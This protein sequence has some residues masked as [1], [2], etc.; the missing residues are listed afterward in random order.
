[1]WQRQAGSI[2]LDP[3]KVYGSDENTKGSGDVEF[4]DPA[5]GSS[6]RS[7]HGGV[8]THRRR[9]PA[10]SP[11]SGPS[12]PGSPRRTS[13][14]TRTRGTVVL[15]PS[16]A[17]PLHGAYVI[18]NQDTFSSSAA[19]TSPAFAMAFY[20]VFDGVRRQRNVDHVGR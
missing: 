11:T 19:A 7:S 18:A 8:T 15:P 13:G 4:G 9:P 6:A 5:W 10:S 3:A 2:R 12:A 17:T 20:I 16:Y 14:P 1:M